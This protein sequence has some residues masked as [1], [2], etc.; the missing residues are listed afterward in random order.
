MGHARRKPQTEA[1]FT[2]TL[3]SNGGAE[4]TRNTVQVWASDSD[5]EFAEQFGEEFLDENDTEAILEY[6]VEAGRLSDDEADAAEIEVET[7]ERPPG[8][9]DEEDEDDDED[10]EDEE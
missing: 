6:L 7:L 10:E 1:P 5:D 2:L 3:L 8:D 9:D 4:L